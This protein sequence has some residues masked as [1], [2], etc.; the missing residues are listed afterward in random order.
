[1][2][3]LLTLALVLLGA[4][5][6]SAQTA[7]DVAWPNAAPAVELLKT[8]A[9][10]FTASMLVPGVGQAALGKRRWALYA[11][12]EVVFWA[13]HLESRS[14]Q[15]A[16]SRAYRNL[17]WD[18]ARLRDSEERVDGSWGYYE[19]MRYYLRS[20]AFDRDAAQ[21][22]LQPE[23]DVDTYNGSV[24]ELSRALYLPGGAGD[25][26]TPEYDQALEHYAARAA[27]PAF[28]WSWE[29]NED[30]WG[31]FGGL[32]GEADSASRLAGGALGAVLAN[33]FVSAVDA[34]LIARIRTE[35]PVRLESRIVAATPLRWSMGLHVPIKDRK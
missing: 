3:P 28:L 4:G 22:G 20:G 12:M 1:M 19:T 9:G 35:S 33:H 27:G 8:P 30:A 25:P 14:D 31:R 23:E 7:A 2:R 21:A 32:I 17:A 24:W 15:R 5:T 13:V 6:A 10:A 34:L 29:G 18:V 26:G 11:G 16:A